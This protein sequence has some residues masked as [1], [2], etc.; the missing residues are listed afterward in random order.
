MNWS[1]SK[2]PICSTY[3][4]CKYSDTVDFN[5]HSEFDVPYGSPGVPHSSTS[6]YPSLLFELED[7]ENKLDSPSPEE[8][9]SRREEARIHESI[10]TLT[11]AQDS[12]ELQV[13]IV[14]DTRVCCFSEPFLY[15]V[16]IPP[17]LFPR[18]F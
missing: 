17:Y 16:L 9:I 6:S 2:L 18:F 13:L 3:S 11:Q 10:R 15:S 8:N 12:F 1:G 14:F 4:R 7:L 5:G